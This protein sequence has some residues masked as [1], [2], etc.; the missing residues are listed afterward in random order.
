MNLN[1]QMERALMSNE[2]VIGVEI[3][4]MDLMKGTAQDLQYVCYD[5]ALKFYD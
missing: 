5:Y 3:V 1:V 4:Q 2:S